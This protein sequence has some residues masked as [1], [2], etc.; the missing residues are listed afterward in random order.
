MCIALPPTEEIANRSLG[1]SD[2]HAKVRS[3]EHPWGTLAAQT[4]STRTCLG[5]LGGLGGHKPVQEVRWNRTETREKRYAQCV[6]RDT[7]APKHMNY[8]IS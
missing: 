5:G 4:V 3:R 1:R 7:C 6:R 2:G 8:S